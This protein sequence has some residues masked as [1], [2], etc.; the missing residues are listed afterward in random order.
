MIPGMLFWPVTFTGEL[1][2]YYSNTSLSKCIV[3]I[4]EDFLFR[5]G[6]L[7]QG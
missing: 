7:V 4:S 5:N 3:L 2:I 1:I 6:N